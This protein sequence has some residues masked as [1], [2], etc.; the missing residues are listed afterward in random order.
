MSDGSSSTTGFTWSVEGGGTIS[1]A[2]LYTAPGATQSTAITVKAAKDGKEGTATI[3]AIQAP[4]PTIT[5]K[6]AI[7][8][9]VG[10][11]TT[12]FTTMFTA[13]NSTASDYTFVVTPTEAGTVNASG[14][15]TLADN[16]TGDVTV[17]ATHK[18]IT[19]VNA[20]VSL[21]GITPKP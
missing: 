3:S 8:G 18:T 15:L 10:G 5:A 13:V 7:T 9:K 1:P 11:S 12:A 17:K 20:T 6:A 14:L 4:S 19:S 16:A 21:T 2:G